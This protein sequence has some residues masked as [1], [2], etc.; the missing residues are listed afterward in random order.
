MNHEE[1]LRRAESFLRESRMPGEPEL[2][3]DYGRV[4]EK[5]GVL[6]IPY[7]SVRFLETRDDRDRLL[8]CWPMLVDLESEVI[9]FG[10]LA[11]RGFWRS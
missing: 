2:G 4:R 6:I 3:I 5:Q 10:E 1:A 11:E 7:N 8:D 9:R